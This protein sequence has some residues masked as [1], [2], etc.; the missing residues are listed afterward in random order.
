[1]PP[2]VQTPFLTSEWF[3]IITSLFHAKQYVIKYVLSTEHLPPPLSHQCLVCENHYFYWHMDMAKICSL[4]CK[5]NLIHFNVTLFLQ[6]IKMP[7]L[8]FYVPFWVFSVPRMI[9]YCKGTM[10]QSVWT[11]KTNQSNFKLNKHCEASS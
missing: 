4:H 7:F 11:V 9:S 5:L 3:I 2:L 1:M 8:M 6:I 10:R